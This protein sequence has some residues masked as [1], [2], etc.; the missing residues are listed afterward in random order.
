MT[1]IGLRILEMDDKKDKTELLEIFSHRNP[2]LVKLRFCKRTIS[3][4]LRLLHLSIQHLVSIPKSE[5]A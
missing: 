4:D 2:D 3:V 1:L 5:R